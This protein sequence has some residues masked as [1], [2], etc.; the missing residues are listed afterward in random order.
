LE[1]TDFVSE[2]F[3]SLYDKYHIKK[4]DILIS[5]TGSYITQP[6][7][8]VGR[9]AYFRNDGDYLLNQRAGKFLIKDNYDK[10][11]LFYVFSHENVRNRIASVAY[12]AANQANVSPSQVEDIKINAP[13]FAMQQKI[14]SILSAYDDLIELNEQRIKILEEMAKLI[15]KEWFVKFRFPGYEKVNMVKSKLGK[16]PERWEVKDLDEVVDK[17]TEKY[18]DENNEL[19]L[20][21][22]ARIPRKNLSIPDYGKSDEIT[23]SRIIFKQYD[24]LF[25]AIRTYFHKVVLAPRNGITNVSVFVIRPK[26]SE[27][28]EFLFCKLFDRETINWATQ[29]SGGT[30]MPVLSWE[31]FKKMRL[32]VPHIELIKV[33]KQKTHPMLEEIVILNKKNEILRQTR[34]MLLPKLIS[35]EIDVSDLDIKANG[36][37]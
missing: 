5:L 2:Q 19:P 3:L 29:N 36:E 21:D 22:L 25:S 12:G 1:E 9:I 23:T 37:I 26:M 15:Y 17:I 31:V 28:L 16:I 6:N 11:F 10:R 13:S 20:L 14:A 32:I 24:I 27:Y 7:S 33:F 4:G 8:V 30:K 18:T 34:D 35:G